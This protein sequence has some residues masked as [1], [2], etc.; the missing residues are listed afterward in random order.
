[1]RVSRI[2]LEENF[3]AEELDALS[4]AFERVDVDE[5]GVLTFEQLP[6][7]FAQVNLSP[8]LDELEHALSQLGKPSDG[9]VD[10]T[11][12]DFAQLADLI[13]PVEP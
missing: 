11:F 9:S 4:L 3:T 12:A 2:S 1:M 6:S 10:Y 5:S 8:T 13:S 7:A